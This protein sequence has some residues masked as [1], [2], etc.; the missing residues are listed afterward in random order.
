MVLHVQV[1]LDEVAGRQVA[2]NNRAGR[3]NGQVEVLLGLVDALLDS[4]GNTLFTPPR[5]PAPFLQPVRYVTASDAHVA[6]HG[7]FL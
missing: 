4:N 1:V 5:E 2:V 7:L 3:D 6:S